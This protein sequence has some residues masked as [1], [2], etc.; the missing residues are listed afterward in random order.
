MPGCD[1]ERF[2]VAPPEDLGRLLTSAWDLLRL[3]VTCESFFFNEVVEE[4]RGSRISELTRFMVS[5]AVGLVT[6]PGDG[7]RR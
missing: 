4:F 5:P 3:N 7:A 1:R 2:N 6:G